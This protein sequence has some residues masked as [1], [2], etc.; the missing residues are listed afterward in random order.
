MMKWSS[1][2]LPAAIRGWVFA[3]S[4]LAFGFL[5]CAPPES[6]GGTGGTGATGGAGGSGPAPRLVVTA[7]WLNQ[8]LT[9]LDYAK[10]T[11]GESDAEASIVRTI[12]LSDWEPGPLEIELT[13]DGKTAVVSVGPGFFDGFSIIGSPDVPPGGTLLVVDLET[14]EAESIDTEDVPMGIA[15]S[16]DGALAYT[17]NYGMTGAPGDSLSVIDIASREVVEEVTVGSRPEQVRLSPDGTIGAIKVTGEGGIRV[18]QTSDI[19]GLLTDVVATGS[20]PSDLTFLGGNDR[21][22]VANSLGFGVTL[23]DT[24]N[25]SEPV[26]IQSFIVQ[27]GV[28][29]GLSFVPSRGSILAPLSPVVSGLPANLSTIEVDG[30]ILRPFLPRALPGSSFPLNVAIDAEGNFAFVAHVSDNQLSIIDLATGA[31]RAIS[32]LTEPGPTYVAVQR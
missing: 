21:L 10:L 31:T 18:F 16:P 9:L 2:G 5:G 19:A 24:S 26:V 17:A 22:V 3:F 32:W 20:D 29:Y 7:D 13:P 23:L 1:P 25:P 8:S 15:I 28:P 30:D 14:G 27:G 4:F 11:D 6:G 12:D